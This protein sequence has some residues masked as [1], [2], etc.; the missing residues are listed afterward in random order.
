MSVS[1]LAVPYP[2][3]ASTMSNVV[4]NP[5]FEVDA[6]GWFVGQATSGDATAARL[7][8][9][10]PVHP[11][12]SSNPGGWFWRVTWWRTLSVIGGGAYYLDTAASITVGAPYVAGMHVRPGRTQRLAVDVA[13]RTAAGAAVGPTVSTEVVVPG[14]QWAWISLATG[15]V[16]AGAV[17]CILYVRNATGASGTPWVAG[18]VLDIDAALL[19]V[20]TDPSAVEYFDGSTPSTVP[21]VRH[22]WT[23]ARGSSISWRITRKPTSAA[24]QS[25]PALLLD[26]RAPRVSTSQLHQVI[27]RPDPLVTTGPLAL[28]TGTIE[29]F[30][31]TYADVVA[32]QRL[33]EAAVVMLR[34]TER[35]EMD[36]YYSPRTVSLTPDP[37]RTREQRWRL[38]VDYVEVYGSAD[39]W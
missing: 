10:G 14:G 21:G 1:L 2:S 5:S 25:T 6:A 18:D 28:R 24:V 20:G 30:Y 22:S 35:P 8:P 12:P 4:K 37:E 39:L 13:W 23:G 19:V 11:V 33:H 31:P 7:G 17:Q 32:A 38:S 15:P 36:M 26:Y 9:F 16:P 34:D 29:L 3:T 27:G